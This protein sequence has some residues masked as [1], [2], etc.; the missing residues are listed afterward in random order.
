M[1]SQIP[2]GTWSFTLR[3]SPG[4]KKVS[5]FDVTLKTGG[6]I[7]ANEKSESIIGSYSEY[8]EGIVSVFVMNMSDGKY[9][10]SILTGRYLDIP[11]ISGMAG[12]GKF[13]TG[14]NASTAQTADVSWSANPVG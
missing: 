12:A 7:T 1:S 9:Q 3:E 10:R 11:E 2:T 6:I 4:I 8:S 14:D 13:I 5:S